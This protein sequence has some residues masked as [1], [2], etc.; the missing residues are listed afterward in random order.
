MTTHSFTVGDDL[1]VVTGALTSIGTVE[2]QR[3]D[4]EKA[5]GTLAGGGT[6]GLHRAGP[7]Q[8]EVVAEDYPVARELADLLTAYLDCEVTPPTPNRLDRRAVPGG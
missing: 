7:H 4:G 6:L 1:D 5:R 3:V 2:V 8:V